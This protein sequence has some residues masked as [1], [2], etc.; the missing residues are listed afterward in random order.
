MPENLSEIL[1]RFREGVVPARADLSLTAQRAADH[2]RACPTLA[3]EVSGDDAPTVVASCSH[4]R[5]A[6][7][8]PKPQCGDCGAYPGQQHSEGCDVARCLW[9]GDQRLKC[10]FDDD[11][12][13]GFAEEPH[14]CGKDI[15][16][17]RW[18]GEAECEE[19]GWWTRWTDNGW[20]RCG[21]DAPGARPD[22]NRL[23]G[24]Q[25]ASWNREAKR[26][27]QW[28]PR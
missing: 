16:T 11:D 24:M 23:N 12:D 27:V 17:G 10:T 18:P 19:F 13:D 3:V 6:G 20:E 25:G 22:L 14:D 5:Q 4:G 2:L 21:P 15:W 9:T 26:W 8:K 28:R 7:W 1:D